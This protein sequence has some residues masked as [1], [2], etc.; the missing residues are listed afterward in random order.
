MLDGEF[1]ETMSKEVVLQQGTYLRNQKNGTWINYNFKG[2]IREIINYK[3]DT[4]HGFYFNNEHTLNFIDGILNGPAVFRNNN[5]FS[6]I[7]GNYL[8]GLRDGKWIYHSRNGK[9]EVMMFE[10][11]TLNGPY[12]IYEN[13]NTYY[14]YDSIIESGYYLKNKLHGLQITKNYHMIAYPGKGYI[15]TTEKTFLNGLENGIRR[16]YR[17]KDR[18][19]SECHYVNG[20][21]EGYC[22]EW[23][24]SGLLIRMHY[25][26]D[27]E[28]YDSFIGYDYKTKL[29]SEEYVRKKR[30]R[31]GQYHKVYPA[32]RQGEP[33]SDSFYIRD[34][35]RIF[36][37]Y[38]YDNYGNVIIEFHI[39]NGKKS[40]RWFHKNRYDVIY[41]DNKIIKT[42]KP[43]LIDDDFG[44][45]WK[46][47][48]DKYYFEDFEIADISAIR[49][50]NHIDKYLPVFGKNL[51]LLLQLDKYFRQHPLSD[52]KKISPCV[53]QF[54]T[55]DSLNLKGKVV[56]SCYVGQDGF[57]SGPK[58]IQSLHPLYDAE[59]LRCI[60]M[61][62]RHVRSNGIISPFRIEITVEF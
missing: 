5:Q 29:K 2:E 20:N 3:S 7:E 34:G 26:N 6:L 48:Y 57:L 54:K 22:N 61:Y 38:T 15:I 49:S 21:R 53:Q 42:I 59:A 18:L 33:Y 24:D 30:F 12:Y 23:T 16:V 37:H 46:Q 31:S 25:Y 17:Q 51:K 47:F 10:N 14:G 55:S 40:G 27:I 11:D 39:E 32:A 43:G 9:I 60:L 45:K 52:N 56:F 36:D 50:F 58:L 41:L 28:E 4:L 8:N 35:K 1:K 44:Y 13:S 19:L 62:S